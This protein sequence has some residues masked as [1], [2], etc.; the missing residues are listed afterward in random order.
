MYTNSNVLITTINRDINLYDYYIYSVT[1]IDKIN[2]KYDLQ[3]IF[4]IVGSEYF[5]IYR[6]KINYENGYLIVT[7]ICFEGISN[8][9]YF[10]NNNINYELNKKDNYNI[11]NLDEIMVNK[12]INVLDIE[13]E[14][15]E[16]FKNKNEKINN[17]KFMCF[18]SEGINKYLCENNF[19]LYGNE[20][21]PGIWDN[22]CKFNEECPFYKKNKNYPNVFSG[23]VDGY[24]QLPL[25]MKNISP[26]YYDINKQPY[27]HNYLKHNDKYDSCYLQNNNLYNK[28]IKYT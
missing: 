8:N 6:Y 9:L 2:I 21:D 5:Y 1:F 25:N 7:K 16:E 3:Y 12:N 19:D 27:C 24:C 10:K 18:G 23:C 15:I 28:V 14:N 13:Q 17:N 22:K 26:H 20:K 11:D 4:S